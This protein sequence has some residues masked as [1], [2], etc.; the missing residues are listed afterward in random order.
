MNEN[1]ITMNNTSNVENTQ[2][3]NSTITR[4]DTLENAS[5]DF[6]RYFSADQGT[7]ESDSQESSS[8]LNHSIQI[9]R[10][11]LPYVNSSLQKSMSVAIKVNE[12]IESF[13]SPVPPELSAC[14]TNNT[15]LDIENMLV[16]IQSVCNSKENETINMILNT[17]KARK[18]YQTYQTMSSIMQQPT[19]NT[20]NKAKPGKFDMGMMEIL[21]AFMPPEQKSMFDNISMILSTMM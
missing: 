17:I 9:I 21:E 4:N 18:F 19:D 2:Y 3:D 11:A 5:I 12:L 20:T 10:A 1:D 16:S 14:S 15:E 6:E 7:Q 13:H 8:N